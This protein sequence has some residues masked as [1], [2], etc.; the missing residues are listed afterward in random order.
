MKKFKLNNSL[1][2][3]NAQLKSGMKP[4]KIDG[5]TTDNLIPMSQKDIMRL[6]NEILVL[7]NRINK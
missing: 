1:E 3:M 6:K 4:E 5:R 7:S 2:R